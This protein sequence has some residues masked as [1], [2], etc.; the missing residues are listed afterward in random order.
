MERCR[1]VSLSSFLA[2]LISSKQL[3]QQQRCR[4][5]FFQHSSSSVYGEILK[6]FPGFCQWTGY[7]ACA[8]M[9]CAPS[10]SGKSAKWEELAWTRKKTKK[11]ATA[12]KRDQPF[13]QQLRD[14]NKFSR[15]RQCKQ[16]VQ[17]PA[18]TSCVQVKL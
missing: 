15:L 1:R 3:F 8:F 14:Q 10:F 16:D 7:C 2:G 5:S 4:S 17:L 6:K 12:I 13:E 18:A 11:T 9:I